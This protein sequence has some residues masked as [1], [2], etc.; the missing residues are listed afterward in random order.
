MEIIVCVYIVRISVQLC[1]SLL[2]CKEWYD[3]S[4][5]LI[6]YVFTQIRQMFLSK[7][8][9]ATQHKILKN[10]DHNINYIEFKIIRDRCGMLHLNRKPWKK[11]KLGK[12]SLCNLDEDENTI[13]FLAICPNIR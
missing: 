2:N 13:H 1:S 9:Q 6:C 10:L 12:C 4:R 11:G 8:L 7:A 3:K 5:A